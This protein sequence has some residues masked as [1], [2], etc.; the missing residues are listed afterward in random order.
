[1]SAPIQ[2][3]LF[4]SR[5]PWFDK[6]KEYV[7]LREIVGIKHAPLIVRMWSRI[8]MA[9]IK[10]DETPWCAAFVGSCLEEV[11]ITS[12]RTGW[13]LDYAKWGQ[14]LDYPAV[15]AIAYKRRTNSAGKVIG[16][17]VAFVAGANKADRVMLL[18][19]NQ[20][21]KVGIDPFVAGGI[22]GYRWPNGYPL[23]PR[24]PLPLVSG[25]T[26]SVTEA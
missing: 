10:D 25:G 22:M 5:T 26:N 11:G 20:G 14:K 3:D 6:A 13:A 12:T 15:G 16:G 24:A 18:G 4:M 1:M 21:N 19:G 9:G 2:G 7:G 23:P 8:K 17:H